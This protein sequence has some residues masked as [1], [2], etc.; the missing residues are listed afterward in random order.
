MIYWIF[1][2]SA[3]FALA[4]AF[5]LIRNNLLNK[6]HPLIRLTALIMIPA[7]L[8]LLF[9]QQ[10]RLIQ[11]RSFE[12]WPAVEARITSSRV[13]GERAYR[14]EI[15]YRYVV[16]DSL[17]SGVTFF[18]RP[19]FG[20]R[21]NRRTSAENIVQAYPPGSLLKVYYNPLKPAESRQNTHL[22]WDFY[23]ILSFAATLLIVGTCIL[24]SDI[25]IHI[26]NRKS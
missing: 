2:F 9:I 25:L 16:D 4:A 20:G 17:I 22:P 7:G 21:V 10:N 18:D 14:P 15:T 23:G 3:L 13:I 6:I 11:Y 26:N 1:F 12:T 24:F 5:G 8:I 19:S